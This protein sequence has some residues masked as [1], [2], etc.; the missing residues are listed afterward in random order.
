METSFGVTTGTI[1]YFF[2]NCIGTF[3][4]KSVF[5]SSVGKSD[6]NGRSN[7]MPR[8][9]NRSGSDM[10]FCRINASPILPPFCSCALGASASASSD[11][12]AIQVIVIDSAGRK[13]AGGDE[14]DRT[15]DRAGVD[16]ALRTQL[17]DLERN[18]SLDFLES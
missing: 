6:K 12:P 15:L 2:R 10:T 18:G 3:A 9:F 11:R 7:W 5:R 1:L 13:L 17:R 8:A 14:L 16:R 4:V